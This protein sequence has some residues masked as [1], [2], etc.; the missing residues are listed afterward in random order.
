M[1][2]VNTLN[3]DGLIEWLEPS[4][5]YL[6]THLS[7]REKRIHAQAGQWIFEN[8]KYQKWRDER[9]SQLWLHGKGKHFLVVELARC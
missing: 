2:K 5:D 8:S 4:E 1:P 6:A 7:I 3:V 9:G